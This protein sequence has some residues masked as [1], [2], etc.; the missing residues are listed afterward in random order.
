MKVSFW[1]LAAGTL[2]FFPRSTMRRAALEIRKYRMRRYIKVLV[3][4]CDEVNVQLTSTRP[5][6]DLAVRTMEIARIEKSLAE[7]KIALT[8]LPFGDPSFIS[9]WKTV[10]D[11]PLI[12]QSTY[13]QVAAATSKWKRASDTETTGLNRPTLGRQVAERLIP[14]TKVSPIHPSPPN[15]T[16][17]GRKWE[18]PKKHPNGFP[19][20][21]IPL[22]GNTVCSQ[23][24]CGQ[25]TQN[26]IC[27]R[28]KDDWQSK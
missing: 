12:V 8:A 4:I 5:S 15:N 11:N 22:Y 19:P 23:P 16:G 18:P 9:F 14:I 6:V 13:D 2:I 17:T 24:G 26:G 25:A 20:T 21:D 10:H 28:H 27:Y 7:L 1:A 3:G